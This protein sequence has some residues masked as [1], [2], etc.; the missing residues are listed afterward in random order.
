[1][2]AI[3]SVMFMMIMV[4]ALVSSVQAGTCSSCGNNPGPLCKAFNTLAG[5]TSN[6][7]E[8]NHFFCVSYRACCLQRL[9]RWTR[10]FTVDAGIKTP[11]VMGSWS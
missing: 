9:C 11:E 10:G 8:G 1:M 3:M 4:F 2:K 7:S 6:G 5:G